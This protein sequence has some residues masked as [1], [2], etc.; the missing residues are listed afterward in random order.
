[1]FRLL[2]I[3]LLTGLVPMPC[4]AE[5][6]D[7]TQ[8]AYL[9]QST[10]VG[11]GTVVDNEL[12]L[13]AIWISSQSRR[14]TINGI[15]AKQGQTLVVEPV[16]SL[17]HKETA[18][19]ST[20]AAKKPTASPNDKASTMDLGELEKLTTVSPMQLAPL[21]APSK[22]QSAMDIP[23]RIL[24]YVN[25]A[26]HSESIPDNAKPSAS[27]PPSKIPHMPARSSTIKII[28]ISNNSVTVDQNGELKTLQLVQRSYKTQ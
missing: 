3:I 6:R 18:P 7:P 23:S 1:M 28:S 2:M 16:S 14:A 17:N 8:P 20:S 10:P 9:Q 27:M 19:T 15:S 11:S 22:G 21:L 13:S 26:Q 5:F 4:S 24:K 12:V 25:N